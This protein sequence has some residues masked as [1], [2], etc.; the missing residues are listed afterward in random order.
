LNLDAEKRREN[1]FLKMGLFRLKKAPQPARPSQSL[2]CENLLSPAS[3]SGKTSI[4]LLESEMMLLNVQ[5]GLLNILPGLK[6]F[7]DAHQGRE[8][9]R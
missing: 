8:S 4:K 6:A 2:P 7:P 3:Q 5:P 9:E 1:F